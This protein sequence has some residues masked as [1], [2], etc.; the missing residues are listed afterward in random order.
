[1]KKVLSVL[2]LCFLLVSLVSADGMI[3]IREDNLWKL[4]S[5]TQQL[6]AINYEDGFENLLISIDMDDETQ[7]DRAIWI[8][9][10]PVN[11]DDVAIDIVKEFPRFGGDNIDSEFKDFLQRT[12]LLMAGYSLFPISIPIVFWYAMMMPMIKEQTVGGARFGKDFAD[13][14]VHERI[15]EAGLT[16]ELITSTHGNTLKAYLTLKGFSLPLEAKE[17]LEHYVSEDHTFVISYIDD[18][19]TFKREAQTTMNYP[20]YY[21]RGIDFQPMYSLAVSVKFPT[22]KI[23]FPLKPTSIYGS[24]TIP[25]ALYV[26]GHVTPELYPK[27]S[28][29][30]EVDYYSQRYY[31]VT[32]EQKNF[33]N[34]KDYVSGLKYTKIQLTAPSKYFEDDL[35]ID[36]AAPV[37]VGI[38]NGLSQNPWPVGIILFIIFSMLSSLVAGIIIFKQDLSKK[39]LLL[40][41]LWNLL[42]FIGFL[43]ATIVTKTKK[44][45]PE[46]EKKI[47][48][49]KV[50]VGVRDYRKVWFVVLFYVFFLVLTGLFFGFLYS[51]L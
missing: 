10:V 49:E 12:P 47:K 24:E 50:R 5:E 35:W 20:S 41:G 51:V 29:Q 36:D 13:V 27:I 7:G 42:T 45:S 2:V 14:V 11:A 3:H 30:A 43:V 38:K 48:Q 33:F 46:L 22:D 39:K 19:E 1:M 9:P 4:Q 37:S 6:A 28:Q 26:V 21:R 34:G 8:F 16:T 17:I 18:L 15:Q 31:G 32:D 25:I 40:F 44:L 23:Y